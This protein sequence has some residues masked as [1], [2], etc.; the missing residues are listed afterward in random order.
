MRKS[1]EISRRTRKMPGLLEV[2]SEPTTLGKIVATQK[3][4]DRTVSAA[5]S[6]AL[7]GVV[8]FMLFLLPPGKA[9]AQ[10]DDPAFLVFGAGYFDFN[11]Q[12]DTAVEFR[13]EYHSD[14]KF[15][16]FKPFGG[17]TGTT[18]ES[19]FF[20]AGI[21]MDLYWG[22]RWVTSLSVAPDIMKKA[23]AVISVII[24]KFA[25]NSNWPTGLTIVPASVFPCHT[26][27]TPASAIAI[28]ARKPSR[29]I[30]LFRS[31]N[32]LAISRGI[33]NANK[34]RVPFHTTNYAISAAK[35][36]VAQSDRAQDS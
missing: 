34:R 20:Y 25:H 21:M 33:S 12:D 35:A 28:R 17:V 19:Y 6:I 10:N 32:Y 7:A 11:K 9:N 16:G 29:S 23:M 31:I 30:I 18:D 1:L 4:K 36:P 8:A 2:K 27:R 14:Y 15:L 24:L 26:C 13:L 3:A 22:R 5:F